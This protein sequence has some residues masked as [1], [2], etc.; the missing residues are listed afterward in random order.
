MGVGEGETM[1]CAEPTVLV[2]I[3]DCVSVVI[4]LSMVYVVLMID[5]V[6]VDTLLS[7][8]TAVRSWLDDIPE[9]KSVESLEV[10][11]CPHDDVHCDKD[12]VSEES[13]L[14]EMADQDAADE[15]PPIPVVLK[16]CDKDDSELISGRD[17]DVLEGV[18]PLD[19]YD[20]CAFDDVAK[21]DCSEDELMLYDDDSAEFDV[22]PEVTSI[23]A[24]EDETDAAEVIC[25]GAGPA[26]D[27]NEE[28]PDAGDELK[29]ETP[30]D[31]AMP[32]DTKERKSEAP[33]V[34]N[35]L[36]EPVADHVKV[37]DS[38]TEGAGVDDTATEESEADRDAEGTTG[39]M[40][41][42]AA[43]DSIAEVAN[44]ED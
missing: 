19:A 26:E 24:M 25:D 40:V 39:I 18:V 44:S 14:L 36:D 10:V 31:G 23:V 3:A 17:S 4:L 41:E 30:C 8:V 22:E 43:E 29:V 16:A 21:D 20:D 15:L 42:G 5:C 12:R 32:D 28:P 38:V 27:P 35:T 6:F 11:G 13:A 33:V 34:D 1:G 9:L 7:E 2:P 37:E